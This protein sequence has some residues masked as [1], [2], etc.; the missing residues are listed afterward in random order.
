MNKKI[1]VSLMTI[2]IVAVAA[3]G[4]TVAYFSSTQ[5]SED[6][7]IKAGTIKLTV[8]HTRQS[9]NGVDC[10][11]C[12]EKLYSGTDDVVTAMAGGTGSFASHNALLVNPINSAWVTMEASLTPAKWVWT[13]NGTSDWDA[14]N[15]VTYTFERTF[16]WW[17]P[18]FGGTINLSVGA[19]NGVKVWL[20]DTMVCDYSTVEKNYQT[21]AKNCSF[22]AGDLHQGTNILKFEVTNFPIAGATNANN[23][24]GLIYN[25]AINGNCSGAESAL[26]QQCQL[27]NAKNLA[28]EKFFNFNDV[29]PGDWGTNVISLHV[30]SN[31]AHV[32]MYVPSYTSVPVQAPLAN[33]INFYLWNDE[34]QNGVQDGSEATITTTDSTLAGLKANLGEIAGNGTKYLGV[35][36]C[37][38]KI[39]G[40]TCNGEGTNDNGYNSAQGNELLADL[41]FYAVQT[42]H[43]DGQFECPVTMPEY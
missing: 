36:W 43:N 38:G 8:D 23:P 17:D 41:G 22:A 29:K 42:R 25:L 9:Y 2:T 40:D 14:Q 12:T 31:D 19:D 3:I 16:Q 26:A 10:Q 34:N 5:T 15:K 6:N 1:I 37:F 20:N 11:T 7:I 39:S 4:G 18:S 33:Y 28:G 13:A 30:T 21:P 24:A 35:R 32:C 27:W